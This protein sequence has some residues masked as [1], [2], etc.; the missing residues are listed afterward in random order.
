MVASCAGPSIDL[1]CGPG[2]LVAALAAQGTPAL[3]I[4][5]SPHAITLA[6]AR[7]VLAIRRDIFRPL[8]GEGRWACALLIDGN[9]GIG[10]DP[11]R[12]LRR[13]A[14]LTAPGG[15]L[16]A[17]VACADVDRRGP[18]RIITAGGV[19][20]QPFRWAALGAPALLREARV[21]GWHSGQV[22]DDGDR[23]FVAL[24]RGGGGAAPSGRQTWR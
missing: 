3:G 12:L 14:R 19:V 4:D 21:A 13:V 8:P 6:R 9:I 5:L 17:E 24:T 18:V 1:G 7:G 15:R 23:R 10:G 16:L 2:R 20:S 22:W 11:G